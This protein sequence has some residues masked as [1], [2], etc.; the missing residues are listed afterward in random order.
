MGMSFN[1]PNKAIGSQ[2]RKKQHS[3]TNKRTTLLVL[4]SLFISMQLATQF[5]AIKFHYHHNLGLS[6][7]HFYLPWQVVEWGLKYKHDYPAYF[8]AAFGLMVMISSLCF[9]L[10][11]LLEQ[12][13]KKENISEYLHGSARWANKE[14]GTHRA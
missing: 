10:I 11:I 5:I 13:K 9:M 3:K 8:N 7:M 6:W 14:C 1:K 2:L 4:L 12:H